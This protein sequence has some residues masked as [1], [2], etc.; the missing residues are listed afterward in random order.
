MGMGM[1]RDGM[2]MQE[3]WVFDNG[4]FGVINKVCII[5]RFG[6]LFEAYA[7]CL[8]SMLL[9]WFLDFSVF[10]FFL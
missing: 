3:I 2:K 8:L 6:F 9:P 7:F 1:K 5:T 4:V 10:I